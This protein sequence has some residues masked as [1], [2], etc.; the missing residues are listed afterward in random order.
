MKVMATPEG[1]EVEASGP[2]EKGRLTK[3][4]FAAGE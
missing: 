2:T 1:Q 4:V 3:R